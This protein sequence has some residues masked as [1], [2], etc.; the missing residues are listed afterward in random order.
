M[1]PIRALGEF[2]RAFRRPW[3]SLL[4]C[5]CQLPAAIGAQGYLHTQGVTNLDINN[6][7]II[8]RGVDLGNWLW[9]EYYMMGNPDLSAYANAGTGT[10]GIAN[11][12]DGL[13]AAIQDLMGGDTNL[14]AQ[15]LDAYWTNFI[16][17]GDI[18]YLHSQ[19]FNSV[20]VPFDFEEFFQVTNWANNYPTNGYDIN[21]GFKY[22]DNLLAWCSSNQ[23]YVIPDFHCPPGGPNNFSVTNYGG[24]LNTNTASVFASAP[25]LSLAGHIWARIAARYA[26]NPWMGGYDLLNEPV[27]TN[28]GGQVGSPILSNTYSNLVKAIRAVDTNH[29]VLCEG[30]YYGS[31]LYDV[32]NTG[33]SDPDSNLSFSDH[34]YGST[35]PLGTGNRSTAVGANVPDWAGEF[36]I[37]ST[38]WYNQ[39]IANTYENPVTLSANGHTSTITEGHCFWAYKSCQFYTVVQNPQ[40]PGWNALLAY[41]ASGETL[42]K[43]S[44][45]NAFNWLIAYAQAA[46]FTNCLTHPEIVDALMRPAV[47]A[48]N[49]GFSQVGLPYK[50]GVTIPGKIF[51]V[52]Y[53]MGSSN[54]TYVDTVSEDEANQGPSGTAWN[55]GWFGRDDGV[56]TTTCSDPG[57]LLKI[58]WNDAGEWQRHTVTCTPGTYN[59]CLRYAGGASGGQIS[60]SL[61]T[62]NS[63]NNSI[64]LTS[65]NISGTISLPST[66]SYTSYATYVVS[67]VVVT[68][69]GLSTLQ[70]NVV[71][72][73]YDLL[74]LEFVPS[75]GPPVPP[76][77]ESRIGAQPG[78]PSGLTAGLEAIGGNSE[79]SLNWVASETATSYNIKRSTTSGGPYITIAFVPSLSYLDTGLTNDVTCYYVISAVNANG[80]GANSTEVNTTPRTTT[81]PSPWVD[82]DIGIAT[83]WS[84]DVADV[85]WP[86]S[87][88]FSFASFKIIGSG[89]DI[90]NQVDSLHFVYRAVSGDCTNV[91]R[92]DNLQ[93]SDPWAKGGI[94]LRDT[95]NPDAIN[96]F[97]TM[98]S[99]NGA[100]FSQRTATG[101]ASSSS[102]LLGLTV[103]YWVKLVRNGNT[104]TGSV[105]SNSSTWTQVGSTTVAMATSAFVGMAVTAHNSTLTNTA[106]F[107]SIS[108]LSQLPAPPANLSASLS[109]AQATLSW[110]ASPAAASYNIQRSTTNNG[111][112][113]LIAANVLA[114]N[115]LDTTA[116]PG[117]TYYYVVTAVNANGESANSNPSALLVTLPSLLVSISGQNLT[118]AWPASDPAFAL[119]TTTNLA[120]PTV[121]SPVTNAV[122][123]QGTNLKTTV[124]LTGNGNRFYRLK[125]S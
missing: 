3:L 24:T 19:G 4:F 36:G 8:L 42:P 6:H 85:G 28:L 14:T 73:G 53:D 117:T 9:P 64:V 39:I 80:E 62:L 15:V 55:S 75:S 113:T 72:P 11:Y 74:W 108:V 79:V 61:L 115:F 16:G 49:Q 92:V 46:N 13:K 59:L 57:T 120:Q 12:Y 50:S 23:I 25:N 26:T 10:G 114:T 44:V 106:I 125:K 37:N 86:G 34:D 87:A 18:T 90:W 5:L 32:D 102:G 38:L 66:G 110:S 98:T 17:A 70:V 40:T 48:L 122:L 7:P 29:L 43:P 47:N 58:G 119:Y 30:D 84:G 104:F 83:L 121:W 105:S 77:G 95:L 123:T 78:V 118:F 67:N 96:V 20:R 101:G 107:D 54:F 56:D 82:R 63:L 116:A 68:N 88:S 35:L 60:V 69:S 94:M 112:Y 81:L 1:S 93:N 2:F 41:W 109:N 103:P 100:L 89:I 45:T 99:Q 51:A 71:N 33:W 31:T 52:D 22:F 76:T 91:V 97:M 27:N 124:P 111:F 65:N 21:T